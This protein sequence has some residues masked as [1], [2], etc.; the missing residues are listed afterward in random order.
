MER[1]RFLSYKGHWYAGGSLGE[2][3]EIH[4]AMRKDLWL[5]TMRPND[6]PWE[7]VQLERR[8]RQYTETQAKRRRKGIRTRAEYE[9][10]SARA[11]AA[12][13]G[14]SRRTYYR[15][16]LHKTGGTGLSPVSPPV[17][18]GDLLV[19]RAKPKER[20]PYRQHR[21]S[22]Q[23]QRLQH[24]ILSILEDHC[25]RYRQ[26]GRTAHAISCVRT[27]RPRRLQDQILSCSRRA[28][29]PTP[30]QNRR[31]HNADGQASRRIPDLIYLV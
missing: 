19:P 12:A 2:H 5:W 30:R 7:Q 9:A 1:D 28:Q 4:N 18:T 20:R 13:L 14:I 8:Q 27:G 15:L 26:D 21:A 29:P 31:Q 11:Q 3:L 23:T 16:G 17:G 10:N 22:R 25:R 6:V 24:R